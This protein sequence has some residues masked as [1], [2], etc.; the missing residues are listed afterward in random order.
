[1]KKRAWFLIILGIVLI[2]TFVL[3][4]TG[5]TVVT[6][7]QFPGTPPGEDESI[8][9]VG[10]GS[11]GDDSGDSSSGTDDAPGITP[12]CGD[13][14]CDAPE[15]AD[16]CPNDCNVILNVSCGNGICEANFNETI[17]TCPEDCNVT[18][19]TQQVT[20]PKE[21]ETTYSNNEEAVSQT[22]QENPEE[23]S[24]GIESKVKEVYRVCTKNNQCVY[25]F[26][27]PKGYVKE[28]ACKTDEDCEQNENEPRLSAAESRKSNLLD[29]LLRA[30][31]IG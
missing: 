5:R 10:D 9:V 22:R 16:N 17:V 18:E 26:T 29:L 24:F 23:D 15:D 20:N 1:M 27:K 28:L 13:D 21:P 7:G 4:L 19:T 31:G 2:G 25:M 11:S 12:V 30:V 6:F 8:V 14:I 3:N